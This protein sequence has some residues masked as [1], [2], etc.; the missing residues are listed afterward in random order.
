MANVLSEAIVTTSNTEFEE[1]ADEDAQ[2]STRDGKKQLPASF[3][4]MF[5]LIQLMPALLSVPVQHHHQYFLTMYDF[6]QTGR[7]EGSFLVVNSVVGA[8]VALLTGLGST[9]PLLL[10]QLKKHKPKQILKRIDL[11]VTILK[12]LSVLIRCSL[13]LQ[14]MSRQT[15]HIR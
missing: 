15:T 7:N 12:L 14:W 10:L 11:S 9:Q 13:P 3:E 2:Q 5:F 8:I 1:E 4:F 6:V